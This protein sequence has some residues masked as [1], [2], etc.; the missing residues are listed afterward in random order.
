MTSRLRV[1]APRH[2]DRRPGSHPRS[3]NGN[4]RGY[5]PSSWCGAR[6]QLAR[7]HGLSCCR[8]SNP[9][10]PTRRVTPVS[11]PLGSSRRG[12]PSRVTQVRVTPVSSPLGSSQESHSSRLT[13]PG[14][15]RSHQGWSA[16]EGQ[17]RRGHPVR[18]TPFPHRAPPHNARLSL[19]S[20]KADPRSCGGGVLSSGFQPTNRR[21]KT[22]SARCARLRRGLAMRSSRCTGTRH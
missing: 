8:R 19:A 7:R 2:L 10:G 3:R 22:K 18:V 21:P 15:G 11:S 6:H 16:Q 12:H 9:G 13:P 1:R 4:R 20:S 17:P 5:L 14:R